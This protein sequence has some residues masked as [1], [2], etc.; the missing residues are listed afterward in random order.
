[1]ADRARQPAHVRRHR[2]RLPRAVL[3]RLMTS[4][5]TTAAKQ[6]LGPRLTAAAR[7]LT[8]GGELASWGNLR[9]T[10]PF[11][12]AFG[13]ERGTPIDRYYLDRFLQAERGA[14]RGAVLEIQVS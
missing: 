7:V 5:L 9:R 13:F 3:R 4:R 11:S 6:L 8:R 10:Q 12:S 1:M 2:A 14:I